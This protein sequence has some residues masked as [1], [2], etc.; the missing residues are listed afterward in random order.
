MYQPRKG[1][2][3][4]LCESPPPLPISDDDA[5]VIFSY[6]NIPKKHWSKYKY[7]HWFVN[8]VRKQTPKI[9]YYSSLAKCRLMEN[10]PIPD[11]EACFY[12]GMFTLENL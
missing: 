9:I 1:K 6:E 5:D 11:F 12:Q 10:S 7:A 4:S 8:I 2:G 3:I